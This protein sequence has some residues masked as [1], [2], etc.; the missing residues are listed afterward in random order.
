MANEKNFLDDLDL[1][2]SGDYAADDSGVTLESI[3]AEFKGGGALNGDG[4]ALGEELHPGTEEIPG[5][6][7]GDFGAAPAPEPEQTPFAVTTGEPEKAEEPDESRR[8]RG[9]FRR[10][11]STRREPE[12]REGP[13]SSAPESGED[14]K[15]RSPRRYAVPSR[16]MEAPP[17]PAYDTAPEIDLSVFD[18]PE[19]S[20]EKA[21]TVD[22][23]YD[24]PIRDDP[25]PASGEPESEPDF[26]EIQRA[27][28]KTIQQ[29]EAEEEGDKSR[30][31]LLGRLFTSHREENDADD[32]DADYDAGPYRDNDGDDRDGD[33]QDDRVPEDDGYVD[34]GPE[35]DFRSE[36]QRYA[37]MVP[38]LRLRILGATVLT[39]VAVIF[40]IM[41][42][43]GS[44]PFGVERASTAVGVAMILELLV[45]ALGLDVLIRGLEDIL[46]LSPGAESLVFVSCAVSVLDGFQMLLTGNFTRGMPMAAVSAVSLL[47]AMSARKSA[48]MALCDSLRAASTTGTFSGVTVDY[49]N[50]EERNILKKVPGER[51]GFYAKLA[52]PDIGESLYEDLAPLLVITSFILA[53]LATVGHGAS[54]AFAHSFS[55]LTA[56]SAAFPATAVFA[57]PFKYAASNL[58][59]AGGALAGYA[60]AEDIYDSDGA[61]ITDQDIFP[62]G[63]VSMSGVKIFEGMDPGRVMVDTSSLI[64]ASGSGLT[65]VF[66]ELLSNQGLI[67]ARVDEFACYDG[68]GIGGVIDGERVLVGTGAFMSLMGLR[69]PENIN[70]TSSVFTA[71]ND[72]LAGVF[73]LEYVPSNSV[74]SALVALLGTSTNLLMAVRD[75]NVTP[76]TVKQKFKVSMDGVEYLPIETTY[77]LSQSSVPDGAGISAVLTRGGLAPFAEVITRGRLLKLITQLNT[78]ITVIGTAL[79]VIIMFFLCW[80]GA[81]ATASATSI[82]LFMSVIGISVYIMSQAA[83]KRMR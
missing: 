77:D 20:R 6:E 59:K 67:R 25:L 58:K 4:R 30:R 56:V 28:E 10:R 48:Y 72:E 54:G 46:T 74:Q 45:M 33:A 5:G 7:P 27:V 69:V 40:T 23:F 82:F 19:E 34:L 73:S 13:M 14:D 36:G 65:K 18:E 83:R 3:L 50:M 80:A 41:F 47:V 60:G 38:S 62:V 52:S 57:L 79:S 16:N 55:I 43:R 11:E 35:P 17:E 66:E 53:F 75:F 21:P 44:A 61:L 26:S 70:T 31:G 12:D 22:D 9:L 1:D 71:I 49:D 39:A 63:S 32:D 15:P 81:F 78:F 42:T 37:A 2:L 51:T 68:G 24:S 29:G 64:I 76:N 8:S